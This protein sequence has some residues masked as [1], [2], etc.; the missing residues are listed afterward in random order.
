[1]EILIQ[2]LNTAGD[3]EY[4]A[5]EGRKHVYIYRYK[6]SSKFGGIAII[7]NLA[8]PLEQYKKEIENKTLKEIFNS[9]NN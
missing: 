1:M 8:I 4:E 2:E 7:M 6:H 5:I 3:I 9:L